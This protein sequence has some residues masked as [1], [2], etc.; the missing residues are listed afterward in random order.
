[1]E[2]EVLKYVSSEDL[3]FIPKD[4]THYLILLFFIRL[5]KHLFLFCHLV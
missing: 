2:M 4:L 5:D 1:M 3:I